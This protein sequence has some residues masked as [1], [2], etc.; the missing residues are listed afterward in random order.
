MD[1]IRGRLAPSPSGRMHLGN[2]FSALIAWL[3]ARSCGGEM[4]LRLEDLDRE[5]CKPE[6][7]EQ[8]IADL[9]WLGLDWDISGEDYYQS[10]RDEI[11]REHLDLLAAKGLIY[12]CFCSR[13]ERIASNAPH[14]SDGRVIYPGTCRCLTSSER[15]MRAS[16]RSPALRL[17]LPCE[18][19]EFCDGVFG[20]LATNLSNE[21]GDII[22]RR[23][24][25]G[26]AYQLAVVVDD[27]LMGVNQVVR[28]RDLLTSSAVQIHLHRLFGFNPPKFHHVPLLLAPDGKRLAKRERHLDMGALRERFSPEK[29]TGLLAHLAGL[30]D[31][32]ESISPHEL[33]PLFSWNKI[34]HSDIYIPPELC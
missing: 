29:L 20:C 12:P 15:E 7:S 4:V 33:I 11:Y 13:A 17:I 22:L 21:W 27:G 28:G 23:S 8:L 14:A 34:P 30:T 10:K 31:K 3:G 19:V 32:A 16:E 18:T 26:Y 1:R 9:K 5:R 25:G 2:A 24:D 6:Y